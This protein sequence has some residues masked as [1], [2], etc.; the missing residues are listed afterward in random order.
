M[1]ACADD[2]L[3][4]QSRTADNTFCGA[5]AD[6]VRRHLDGDLAAITDLVVLVRPW[7]YRVA[8][9]Y[10]LPAHTADDVAQNA[11]LA[12]W[13]HLDRIRNPEATVAW[14][15]VVARNEAFRLLKLEGGVLPM[16]DDAELQRTSEIGNPEQA[17]LAE[18]TR[19][20][21]H[22]NLAKLP[23]RGRDLLLLAFLADVRDYA[24][25][26]ALLEMP[27]G[28][29]GPTRKRGLAKM[30]AL[31]EADDDWAADAA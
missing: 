11:L 27:I 20:A 21:V 23:A 3:V 13:Q 17:L 15:A 22:R 5:V 8:R 14:L 30:R 24:T 12:L 26:S 29:I 1:L 6:T 2:R 4:E 10:R 18:Q 28:S 16:G 9:G 25:I 31:L 19:R 7:L